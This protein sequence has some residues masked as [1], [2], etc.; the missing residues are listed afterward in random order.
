MKVDAISREISDTWSDIENAIIRPTEQNV[1]RVRLLNQLSFTTKRMSTTHVGLLINIISSHLA[2]DEAYVNIGVWNGFSF[3]AGVVGTNSQAIA[4]DSFLVYTGS[5]GYTGEEDRLRRDFGDAEKIFRG[6]FDRL[7]G[8]RQKYFIEDCWEFLDSYTTRRLPKIGFYFYDGDHS[9]DN[10]IKALDKAESLLAEECVIL[11]DD[12]NDQS[13]QKANEQWFST[14]PEFE[15]VI[16]L[17][18]PANG[19]PTW[20]N[21]LDLYVRKA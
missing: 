16:E 20:W 17:R 8:E 1:V 14:R 7:C 10:Q 5:I 3:F 9:L 2:Q 18:T 12:A 13:V 19:W 6:E 15:K 21:G 4:N 11:I